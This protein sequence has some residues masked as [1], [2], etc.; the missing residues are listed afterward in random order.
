MSCANLYSTNSSD[1]VVLQQ[2]LHSMGPFLRQI[3]LFPAMRSRIMLKHF[4]VAAALLLGIGATI[5]AD[6]ATAD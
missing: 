3:V 2:F 4:L 5:R 1:A 6:E